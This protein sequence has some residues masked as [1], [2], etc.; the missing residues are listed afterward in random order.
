MICPTCRRQ[1]QRVELFTSAEW[2]CDCGGKSF[3]YIILDRSR[4]DKL[5]DGEHVLMMAFKTREEAYAAAKPMYP[6]LVEAVELEDEAVWFTTTANLLVTS[7][8]VWVDGEVFRGRV[9]RG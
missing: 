1:M 2:R 8:E 7:C 6:A 5:L 4:I 9:G 3:G